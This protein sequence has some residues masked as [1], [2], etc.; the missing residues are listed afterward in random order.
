[1]YGRLVGAC[2][3]VSVSRFLLVPAYWFPCV[4]SRVLVSVCWFPFDGSRVCGFT[5]A[6]YEN[7]YKGYTAFVN[8]STLCQQRV[9]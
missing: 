7:I 1:M 5:Q 8:S 3:L 6:V 4:G 2:A 9:L